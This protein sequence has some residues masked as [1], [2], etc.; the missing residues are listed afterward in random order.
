M[1]LIN[2]HSQHI[3]TS[4]RGRDLARLAERNSAVSRAERDPVGAE[5]SC[6]KGR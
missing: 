2:Y 4:R 3:L 6:A 1:H 5:I